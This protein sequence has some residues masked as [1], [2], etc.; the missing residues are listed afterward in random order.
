MYHTVC[1]REKEFQQLFQQADRLM[2]DLKD[3]KKRMVTPS[4]SSIS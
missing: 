1:E 2:S 3:A 4:G